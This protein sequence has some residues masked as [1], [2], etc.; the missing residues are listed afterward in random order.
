MTRLASGRWKRETTTAQCSG[1]PE[2]GVPTSNA[3][4]SF[5]D[6]IVNDV[7]LIG[8]GL[9]L[10]GR[11]VSIDDGRL[12]LLAVDSQDRWVVIEVKPGMIDSGAL[13]QAIY[14]A[15]SLARLDADELLGKLEGGF[16]KVGDPKTLSQRVRELLADEGDDR[17]IALLLVG[18]GIHRDLE[19]TSEFLGRFAS[20]SRSFSF[21]CSHWTAARSC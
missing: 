7:T 17:E 10:V 9:L 18:A 4:G 21:G 14:Y 15:S 5:E 1:N 6:W 13:G 11:Q 16:N 3:S 20:R 8:E 12:D 19:R 2:G